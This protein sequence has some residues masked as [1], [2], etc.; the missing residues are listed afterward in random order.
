[1]L[2]RKMSC[3]HSQHFTFFYIIDNILIS[4]F[5][6]NDS[7]IYIMSMSCLLSDEF[8]S[9]CHKSSLCLNY[10]LKHGRRIA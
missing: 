10:N 1:M 8:L 7:N 6:V 5:L 4:R 3:Q 2:H 9:P